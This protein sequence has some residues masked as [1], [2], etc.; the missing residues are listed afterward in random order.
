MDSYNQTEYDLKYEDILDAFNDHLSKHPES[1][2]VKFSEHSDG[3]IVKF[4]EHSD[5]ELVKYDDISLS[6]GEGAFIAEKNSQ[7]IG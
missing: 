3:G 5:G 2:L 4:S 7:T 6:Y 1:E